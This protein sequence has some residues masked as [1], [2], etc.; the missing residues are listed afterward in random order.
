MRRTLMFSFITPLHTPS[1]KMPLL[2]LSPHW[3]N[4][5]C[6]S[7]TRIS[8]TLSRISCVSP[9]LSISDGLI[10]LVPPRQYE[11]HVAIPISIIQMS[12]PQYLEVNSFVPRDCRSG[13]QTQ[14][15]WFQTQQ[16]SATT[17]Q[18]FLRNLTDLTASK[19]LWLAASEHTEYGLSPGLLPCVPVKSYPSLPQDSLMGQFCEQLQR[20]NIMKNWFFCIFSLKFHELNTRLLKTLASLDALSG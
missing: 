15:T 11:K 13:V 4:G 6:C 17:L 8:S 16:F 3:C 14:A 7:S 19:H 1:A 9:G 18:C 5:Y 2:L 10:H 20:L 12:K